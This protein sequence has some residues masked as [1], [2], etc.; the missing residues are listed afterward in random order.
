MFYGNEAKNEQ[1]TSFYNNFPINLT[2]IS[3]KNLSVKMDMYIV[4]GI[5]CHSSQGK[6]R[7]LVYL[8]S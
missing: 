2:P 7:K 1:Y 4:Q 3:S 5:L 6:Y 8:Y